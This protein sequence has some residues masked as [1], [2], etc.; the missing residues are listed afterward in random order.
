MEKDHIKIKSNLSI[1]I[2]VYNEAENIK[3]VLESIKKHISVPFELLLIY[4]QDSDTTLPAAQKINKTLNLPLHF[5]KNKYNRG[6]LN[7]LKTGFET[8]KSKAI[9]VT[10]ADCCDDL[11]D[12][13][14]GLEL[15]NEGTD[16]VSFSR[17]MPGGKLVDAPLL[18]GF[19]GKMG[20]GGLAWNS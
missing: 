1:I 5:I 20:W 18:K 14:K 13:Q 19:L 16:L 3:T 17:Y 6:A 4:D 11:S 9:L 12:I 8:A 2:P 7:A 10:M 15:F